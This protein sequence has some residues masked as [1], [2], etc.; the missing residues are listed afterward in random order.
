MAMTLNSSGAAFARARI[1]AGDYDASAA[2]SFSAAD[3]DAMLG[4]NGDNWANY[5]R[6][7]LGHD[8]TQPAAT[9]ARFGYPVGKGGK[10]YRS[11]LTAIPQRAAAQGATDI[12]DDA[13][14]LLALIDAKE[15]GK[16]APVTRAY[17]ILEIK[18]INEDKRIIEGIASTVTTDR[19]DDIVEPRGAI[20][21]LPIPFLWQ[22][23]SDCPVG[24]VIAA[25]VSDTQISVTCQFAQV[26][27]PASLQDDL[28]RAWSMVKSGLVRGLSIGFNPI[29]T[30]QI[31]GSWGRRYLKWEL[32]ELSAVTIPANAEATITTIRSIAT[33]ERAALGPKPLRIIRGS[34]PGAAG[35]ISRT[36]PKEGNPVN[37]NQQISSLEGMRGPKAARFDELMEKSVSAGRTTDETERA[38]LQT[39]KADLEAIDVDLD[40]LRFKEKQLA[41]S[42]TPVPGGGSPIL[43]PAP[44]GTHHVYA[45]AKEAK[46]APGVRIYRMMRIKALG[47]LEGRDI[48]VI[49]EREY[50]SRD[51]FLVHHVK[52]GEVAALTTAAG[53]VG[54]IPT[55]LGGGDYAEF[56]RPLTI[57][58]RFGTGNI[59][60]LTGTPF[61]AG[62]VSVTTGAVGYWTGEA[63]PKP[64]TTL[65]SSRT[66]ILPLKVAA[67]IAVS[68]E[69]LRDSSPSI[70]PVVVNEMT[71]A[72]V[73][74]LDFTFIDPSATAVSGVSPA[75]ITNAQPSIVSTGTDA[76]AVRLD[77]RALFQ[78]YFDADNQATQAVLVMSAK[79]ATALSW[80]TNALGQP[81]FP[82]MTQMGGMIHGVPVIASDHIAS[83]VAL[84]SASD[85]LLAQEGGVEVDM[86]SEA[87]LEMKDVDHLTQHGDATATGAS[88]VSMFQTNSVA[89]R[90]ERRMNWLHRRPVA[91]PYLTSVAW[92]GAVPAS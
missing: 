78:K 45:E 32:L 46:P 67:I 14:K 80:M 68:M 31:E 77:I 83:D 12:E 29:E 71:R 58:G 51:P 15:G 7:H 35:S 85:I 72:I 70:E 86:S 69:D 76:D 8:M 42:A 60:P 26:D 44:R 4:A 30:A 62:N 28:D 59:P 33:G 84:V 92:G 88:M 27:A 48:G 66:P 52:A 18:A 11:A 9:K 24:Q 90:A 43:Q 49:A 19:M 56:L 82:G 6:W 50:G 17:S 74:V 91:A 39:L 40:L 64:L 5:D 25:K 1:A 21:N 53:G 63:K 55:D 10:V 37:I 2:W 22:H 81:E 61:R 36:A 57:I 75:S 41:A 20:F 47:R 79:N 13:G 23:D 87:S 73:Q 89:F 38:E 34:S 3:G 65:A 16:S 54:F